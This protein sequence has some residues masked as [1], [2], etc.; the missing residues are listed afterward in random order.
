MQHPVGFRPPSAE[1]GPAPASSG[2]PLSP[3]LRVGGA[4]P[5]T[6]SPW[7]H[8]RRGGDLPAPC[9]EDG[10]G[11]ARPAERGAETACP[12][13]MADGQIGPPLG[14]ERR[15]VRRA[16]AL[17]E[18]LRAGALLP[19]ASALAAFRGRLFDEHAI[20]L[21]LPP[22]PADPGSHAV[23][24]TRIGKAVASLGLAVPGNVTPDIAASAPLVQRLA[25][26]AARA[27]AL[28]EPIVIEIDTS[29]TPS[30]D[31]LQPLLLRAVALPFAR[32][33]SP[34]P[35][36]PHSVIVAS[37]RHLLPPQEA[38]AIRREL[39]SAIDWLRHHG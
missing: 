39:A 32:S 12:V 15:L 30:P 33:A 31:G 2:H 14:I 7:R 1:P 22:H 20:E 18:S 27:A 11:D 36:G 3:N 8:E 5:T 37:W 38:D 23:R 10:H 13:G 25:A 16:E 35:A 34:E 6:R 17:W 24:I 29:Q 4:W 28:S 21:A 26:I 19:P 9:A